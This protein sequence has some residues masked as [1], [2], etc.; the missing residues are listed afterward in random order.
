MLERCKGTI[1][2]LPIL[3]CPTIVVEVTDTSV[4]CGDPVIT[5]KYNIKDVIHVLVNG[6]VGVEEDTGVVRG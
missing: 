6:D 2:W 5:W 3:G 4:V 1:F